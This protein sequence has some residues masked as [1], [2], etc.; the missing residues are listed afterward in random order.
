ME[1]DLTFAANPRVVELRPSPESSAS[2]PVCQSMFAWLQCSICMVPAESTER[3][4][5]SRSV[6]RK[7]T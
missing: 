1:A 4:R 5:D 3:E 7:S 2:S 6:P